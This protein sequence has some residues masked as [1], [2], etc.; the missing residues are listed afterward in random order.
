[1]RIFLFVLAIAVLL[2]HVCVAPVAAESSPVGAADT[3][4]SEDHHDSADPH[5]GSCEGTVAKIAPPQHRTWM[6][7]ACEPA[8]PVA[9]FGYDVSPSI[10]IPVLP[11]PTVVSD[12]PL[13]LLH[14]SLL[15]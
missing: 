5:G 9:R 10:R 7:A 1:M 4:A 3:S 12:R 14:A 15:I 8:S 2:G 13:F 11:T 6:H